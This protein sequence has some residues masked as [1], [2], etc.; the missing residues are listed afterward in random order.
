[1]NGK[2]YDINHKISYEIN[3]RKGFINEF[4]SKGQLL[5]EL[6]YLNWER[7]GKGKE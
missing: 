7:N 5:F 1:M 6:E 3:N 4:Y 2:G